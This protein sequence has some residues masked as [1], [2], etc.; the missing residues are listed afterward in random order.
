MQEEGSLIYYGQPVKVLRTYK[1]GD[2]EFAELGG[3]LVVFSTAGDPDLEGEFF[4]KG[5]DLGIISRKGRASLPGYYQHGFD[6]HFKGDAV[7]DVEIW[8]ADQNGEPTTKDEA[9]SVWA[10]YQIEL[11]SEYERHIVEMARNGKL[12]QSS[13]AVAHLVQRS[14]ITRSVSHITRW[15]IGEASLTPTPAEPRTSAIPLKSFIPIPLEIVKMP[16]RVTVELELDTKAFDAKL[17]NAAKRLEALT[18]PTKHTQETAMSEVTEAA[19]AVEIVTPDQMQAMIDKAIEDAKK[20]WVEDAKQGAPTGI[21][22]PNILKI[23]RGD[24][25][26][27]ALCHWIRSGDTGGIKHMVEEDFQ[28]QQLVTI[29]A[30]PGTNEVSSSW[31]AFKASNDTDM[32]IGTAADGGHAV[33]AGH[34]NQIIARRDEEMIPNAAGCRL[35]PGVGTTVSVPLDGEDDGEFVSTNEAA[36]SDRDAPALGNKDLTLVVYSK[37]LDLSYELLRDETSGILS[38]ISLHVGRGSAKTHNDLF[39]TEVVTNGTLFKTFAAE[40]TF[41][42]GELED[43]EADDNLGAYLDN[44]TTSWVMRNSTLAKIRQVK[45]DARWYGDPATGGPNVKERREVLGYPVFRTNK[46]DAVD[47]SAKSVLFGNWFYVGYRAPDGLQFLRDPYSKAIARQ[48][49]LHY[50]FSAVYGTLQAEAVGYGQHPN[51]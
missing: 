29:G 25:Y 18:E 42:T 30:D 46:V 23:A 20:A 2:A 22:A 35:I 43:L 14:P 27:K 6:P 24:D 41:A 44:S 19:K 37:Y 1:E 34:L 39:V 5:T 10:Q 28:G 13:G 48:I 51:T 3:P 33:P 8:Y 47:Q 26:A 17:E 7:A 9:F 49:R 31:K 40:D 45:G 50:Y 38:Y 16:E 21:N 36:D 32:N 4:T 11:R 15:P 12:G